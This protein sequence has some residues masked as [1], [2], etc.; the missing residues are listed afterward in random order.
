MFVC[1]VTLNANP[2][3]TKRVT[4]IQSDSIAIERASEYCEAERHGRPSI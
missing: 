4:M 2:K 3:L 1:D